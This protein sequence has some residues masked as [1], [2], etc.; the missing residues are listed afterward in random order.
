MLAAQERHTEVVKTLL[1]AGTSVTPNTIKY[2]EKANID[3]DIPA[4]DGST[5]LLRAVKNNQTDIAEVLLEA[6]ADP[7][8]ANSKDGTT[9]LQAAMST[10]SKDIILLITKYASEEQSITNTPAAVPDM[11]SKSNS[12]SMGISK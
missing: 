11:Y 7:N 12:K 5:L 2:I 8:K 1:E 4:K 3:I 10:K 6:G 9:P